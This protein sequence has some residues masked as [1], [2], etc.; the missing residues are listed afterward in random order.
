[1]P[2]QRQP[3]IRPFVMK[4]EYEADAK[5]SQVCS[6]KFELS[7]SGAEAFGCK[8]AANP[9]VPCSECVS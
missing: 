3:Y 2:E 8:L 4:L 5:V 9:L 1:M 7:A 6:C